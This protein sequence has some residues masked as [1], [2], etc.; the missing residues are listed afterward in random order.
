MTPDYLG[1][2]VATGDGGE[3]YLTLRGPAESTFTD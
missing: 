2:P 3:I 1:F